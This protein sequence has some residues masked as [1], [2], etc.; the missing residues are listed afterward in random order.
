MLRNM[1]MH[2]GKNSKAWVLKKNIHGVGNL[3]VVERQYEISIREWSGRNMRRFDGN[4]LL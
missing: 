3:H 2:D 4:E 1:G